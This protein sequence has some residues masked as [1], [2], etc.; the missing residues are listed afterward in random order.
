MVAKQLTYEGVLKMFRK[1][2]CSQQNFTQTIER[3]TLKVTVDSQKGG[4]RCVARRH[5][6]SVTQ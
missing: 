5:F 2:R 4:V 1:T 3:V 6:G